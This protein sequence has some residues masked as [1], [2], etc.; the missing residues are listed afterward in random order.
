VFSYPAG[1]Q[2]IDRENYGLIDLVF[3]KE[4]PELRNNYACQ[5]YQQ[6]IKSNIL[7]KRA[8]T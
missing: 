1:W 8:R 2:H 3:V 5:Q 4:L 6:C 7:Q